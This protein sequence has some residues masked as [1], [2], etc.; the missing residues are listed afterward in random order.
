H[1]HDLPARPSSNKGG[2]WIGAAP[3][4]LVR[5]LRG[6]AMRPR[7]MIGSRLANVVAVFILVSGGV[8][9]LSAGSPA[10]TSCGGGQTQLQPLT[11]SGQAQLRGSVPVIFVHGINSTAGMWNAQ[12]VAS[13]V[14]KLRGVTAWTFNYGPQSLEWVDNRAIGPAL[15]DAISCLA[16]A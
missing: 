13:G 5:D 8:L 7:R 1:R 3:W 14:T 12:S 15:A 2:D 11:R 4:P 10:T 9:A 16:Q 6:A